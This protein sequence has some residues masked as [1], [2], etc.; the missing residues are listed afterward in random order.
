M[1]DALATIFS[2][3]DAFKRKLVDALRNPRLAAEQFVGDANDRARV[4][5]EMT[6]AAAQE[7]AEFGPASRALAMKM[8]EAYGPTGM[9]K[10]VGPQSAA[11]EAARKNAV[12]MLGL[13]ENNTAMD[14]AKALGFT[15]EVYHGTR[16]DIPAFD[17]SKLGEYTGA[18]TAQLG[19]FTTDNPNLAN[20]FA[21][22]DEGANVIPLLM[23][24]SYGGKEALEL[25]HRTAKERTAAGL[26]GDAFTSMQNA[27]ARKAG[28]S[29]WDDV[30]SQDVKAW[31]DAVG[32]NY[33]SVNLLNTSMDSAGGATAR[34]IANPYH[35]F[36]IALH[37]Q[38][39]RS[40]FAAFDPARVNENNLLA[41]MLPL[42]AMALPQEEKGKKKDNAQEVIDALRKRK[43]E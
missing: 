16:A 43:P 21:S 33:G 40:R 25:G 1:S 17:H 12:K 29:S 8:A 9:T 18:R 30:T 6:S 36:N 19:T 32:K 34:T 28:K 24:K 13:P 10:I 27:I 2:R 5:N 3:S 11:L 42:G 26:K 39:L 23:N 22:A 20:L 14:R 41:G 38:Q 7:G 37:P 31:R 15:D 4:L 35:D